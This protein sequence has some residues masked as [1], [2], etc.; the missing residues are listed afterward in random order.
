MSF[1]FLLMLLVEAQ[2]DITT[3][4]YKELLQSYLS[5]AIGACQVEALRREFKSFADV[6]EKSM[7][8]FKEKTE[9][10]FKKKQG[11]N[12]MKNMKK[13]RHVTSFYKNGGAK[14]FSKQMK[15]IGLYVYFS[16]FR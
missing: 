7:D 9:A 14:K 1:I 4:S 13:E 12:S 10:D 11:M 2:A 3:R 8:D 5:S 6:I 16:N 15:S